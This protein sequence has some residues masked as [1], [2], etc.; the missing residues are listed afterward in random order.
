MANPAIPSAYLPRLTTKGGNAGRS[1]A[2]G[3]EASFEPTGKQTVG[4]VQ[5]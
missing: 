3:T 1:M 4:R 2:T 5:R